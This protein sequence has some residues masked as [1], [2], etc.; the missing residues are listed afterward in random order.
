MEG[1][2]SHVVKTGFEHPILLLLPPRCQDSTVGPQS[3]GLDEFKGLLSL[4]EVSTRSS[5]L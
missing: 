3:R 4:P 1:I 5:L 2:W